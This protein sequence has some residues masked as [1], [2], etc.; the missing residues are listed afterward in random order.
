MD[1]ARA[2]DVEAFEALVRRY[3]LPM[4][5]VALRMLASEGDA[6]DA[7]QEAFIL[8]W[9]NLARFRGESAYSTWLYRIVINRCLSA[10]ASHRPSEPL[11]ELML[12]GGGDPVEITERRQRWSAIVEAVRA[13]PSE[14]RAALV[15]REFEGLSYA[16]IAAVLGITVAAV[17]GRIHRARLGVIKE[18]DR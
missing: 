7:T 13:L 17:K 2:G 6:E 18:V 16:E 3:Q 8:A 12:V 1:A 9:Q 5:R 11:E 15:L 10:R 4:Y 14:Q